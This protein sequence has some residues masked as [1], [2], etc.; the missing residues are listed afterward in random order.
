MSMFLHRS[1]VRVPFWRKMVSGRLATHRC[2]FASTTPKT[3]ELSFLE[4]HGDYRTDALHLEDTSRP[5]YSHQQD[6]PRL[7]VPSLEE[8]VET[9][10]PT[11]LPLCKTSEERDALV[12]AA[13]RFPQQAAH[14]QQRLLQRQ[15]DKDDSSWLQEWW[16]QLGYLKVRSSNFIHVSYCLSLADDKTATS[17]ASRA[18]AVLQ[19]AALFAETIQD[20][21]RDADFMQN[22]KLKTAVPLCSSQYKYIFSSCRIPRET[23]DGYRVYK[24]QQHA[25]VVLRGQFYRIPITDQTGTVLSRRIL[26]SLLFELVER[27]RTSALPELGWLTATN[28]DSWAKTYALLKNMTPSFSDALEELQSGLLL[29]CLDVDVENEMQDPDRSIAL[30]Y[31]HGNGTHTANRWFDKSLQLIVSDTPGKYDL[32]YAGEHSMADGMPVTGVCQALVTDGACDKEDPIRASQVTDS[33]FQAEPVFEQAFSQLSPSD[34][35]I[36]ED[37]IETA[38]QEVLDNIARHDMQVQRFTGYGKQRIKE[39]GYSP[40]A[41]CQMALQLAGRRLFGETVGTYESTHTRQFLHGRTETTRSVSPA[42]QAFCNAML[43]GSRSTLEEKGDLLRRAVDS[44]VIYTH[45]ALVGRGVDR[46]FLGLTML[47]EDGEEPP[48]LMQ[49]PIYAESKRWRMSTSTLPKTAPGFGNVE[50]DGVGI[51]YDVL[52]DYCMFTVT[53]EKARGY[54]LR[55]KD[56]IGLSLT[57]MAMFLESSEEPLRSKL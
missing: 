3:R 56:E 54:A 36:V 52:K 7:P 31:W 5:L 26:E 41:F 8:T 1:I 11:A 48:D 16:N 47:L 57:D 25:I 9:F 22:R 45:K 19:T 4:S 34:R 32:G 51:G 30:R 12:Q 29:L 13:K 2:L 24:A 35:R 55:M 43:E 27:P 33:S 15:A 10:L 50:P 20:G 49:H 17:M 28:R 46:H 18:A 14:L 38:R 40:D 39:A 37:H 53:A 23:Q 42:S 21:S 6:L 44:H